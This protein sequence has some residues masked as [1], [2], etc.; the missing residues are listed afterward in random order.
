MRHYTLHTYNTIKQLNDFCVQKQNEDIEIYTF[1]FIKTLEL[2][3]NNPEI[4]LDITSLIQ[5]ISVNRNDVL[6]AENNLNQLTEDTIVIV[7]SEYAELA[8]EL[9]PYFFSE[10]T[11]L[12][13]E[14]YEIEDNKLIRNVVYTY[15]QNSLDNIIEYCSKNNIPI[16]SFPTANHL[17][18]PKYNHYNSKLELAIV[19]VS[20]LVFAIESNQNLTY[21]SEQFFGMLPNISIIIKTSLADKLL[22]YFPLYFA[23]QAPI[24]ELI[25]ELIVVDEEMD[26]HFKKCITDLELEDYKRFEDTIENNLIG[27]RSFKDKLFRELS[28]FRILNKYKEQ[29]VFSIFLFGKSGIGKTELARIICDF[30]EKDTYLAKINFANYN[31]QDALNSLIGS[32]AGYVGCNDGELSNKVEKTRVGL[33]LCDE[34]EKATRTVFS[35]FLEMLEDGRFTDS[36]SREYDVDGFIIVFT[37]NILSESE[38]L[39]TIPLE[40]QTRFDIVCE[41]EDPTIHD[42]EAFVKLLFLKSETIYAEEFKKH[43]ITPTEKSQLLNFNFSQINALRDIKRIFNHRMIEYLLKKN[44]KN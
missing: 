19:D 23:T 37:S 30:L 32:P 35:F 42:K 26:I 31:R 24:T 36:M 20:S 27:H 18:K 4:V 8:L 14:D 1:V 16:S 28:N 15:N 43:P 38:Y 9:L 21:L 33:V 6:P 40:L 22:D 13:Q 39:K 25:E 5:H 44:S 34:F 29:K 10:I 7:K 41:F 11:P 3:E 12:Y 17:L 2:L